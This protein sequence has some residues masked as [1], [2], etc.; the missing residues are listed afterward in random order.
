MRSYFV[1]QTK[2]QIMK[3]RLQAQLKK[4]ITYKVWFN[5]NSKVLK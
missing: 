5:F 1:S 3:K 2:S 4:H